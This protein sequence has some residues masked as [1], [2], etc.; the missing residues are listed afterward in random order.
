M[1]GNALAALQR[2]AH[3]N[4]D[5]GIDFDL[6]NSEYPCATEEVR[7]AA[8]HEGDGPPRLGIDILCFSVRPLIIDLLQTLLPRRRAVKS[9][10]SGSIKALSLSLC[11]RA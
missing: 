10:R 9:A 3:S 4:R 1:L 6:S 8:H 2:A 11:E 5:K 7:V